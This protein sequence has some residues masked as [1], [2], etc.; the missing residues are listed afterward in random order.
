MFN[1]DYDGSY[2]RMNSMDTGKGTESNWYS[3]AC[4]SFYFC[5]NNQ[6]LCL[7]LMQRCS[8]TPI[9]S[10]VWRSHKGRG[11]EFSVFFRV[12]SPPNTR[13]RSSVPIKSWPWWLSPASVALYQPLWGG[14]LSWVSSASSK[15]L[16]APLTP[17]KNPVFRCFFLQRRAPNQPTASI[18][19]VQS[20]EMDGEC[21]GTRSA[22]H[23]GTQSDAG[24]GSGC[25][26]LT[27]R[28]AQPRW[29]PPRTCRWAEFWR[30]SSV[31]CWARRT[32]L[33]QEVP[34][35]RLRRTTCQDAR[36]WPCGASSP[37]P[38]SPKM[39]RSF[40]RTWWVMSS[41]KFGR[42]QRGILS[43]CEGSVNV[44]Q[45]QPLARR[46]SAWPQ[47]K[48]QDAQTQ[49]KVYWSLATFEVWL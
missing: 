17:N 16:Q 2:V 36:G 49:S 38:R 12:H 8:L 9:K 37:T 15:S 4:A 35:P 33:A 6:C 18:T 23:S 44:C 5:C 41:A 39:G 27:W 11:R 3:W 46:C 22:A 13:C 19:C 45:S 24:S 47:P 21:S 31:G 25:P 42:R 40:P 28:G 29:R 30:I 20:W 34:P 43:S 7:T 48:G 1:F 32:A 14:R 26:P 10:F